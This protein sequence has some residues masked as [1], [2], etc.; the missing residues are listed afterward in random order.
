MTQDSKT[1]RRVSVKLDGDTHGRVKSH[2]RDEETLSGTINR[3]LDA[4]EGQVLT[5]AQLRDVLQEE[6]PQIIAIDTDAVDGEI[7][8]ELKEALDSGD[9]PDLAEFDAH[10][11]TQV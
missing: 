8:D 2:N 5:E 11:T 3:A 4:L 6:R 7:M 1:E 9:V 10:E